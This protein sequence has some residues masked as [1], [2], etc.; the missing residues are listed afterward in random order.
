MKKRKKKVQKG[1]AG[2]VAYE[3]KKRAF[4]TVIMFVIPLVIFFSGIAYAHTRKNILT[5]VA[6]VGILP[7]A[8]CAVNWIMILLQ[9]PADP[10]IVEQTEKK[11]GNLTRGYELMI[12]AYEGRLP[13]DA[14]V[15]CG[16]Q[17][18]C[19]CSAPK[20][21]YEFMEKHMAKI[22]SSNGYRS[23][24]VKIF[25]ERKPYLERIEQLANNPEKYREGIKFTPD[26]SY[27][28]L[29][30]EELILHVLMAISV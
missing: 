23:V 20:G 1:S 12:T 16:N 10:R 14:L 7:A 13:L 9:K 3:R 25:R 30:R 5:V 22:L 27:P 18:A 28:D 26:E 24:K 17:V 11:A 29:S 4:I 21:K 19:Y 8:K 2:Y 15:V 6:V